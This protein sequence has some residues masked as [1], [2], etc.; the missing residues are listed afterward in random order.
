MR[1]IVTLFFSNSMTKFIIATGLMV[2][3][4]YR[5][6]TGRSTKTHTAKKLQVRYLNLLRTIKAPGKNSARKMRKK[7]RI[8]NQAVLKIKEHQNCMVQAW[9][10]HQWSL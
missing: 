8:Q 1:L 9:C 7:R 10:K 2:I 5:Y 3:A 6:R 4:T